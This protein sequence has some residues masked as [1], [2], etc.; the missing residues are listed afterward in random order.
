MSIYIL[1]VLWGQPIKLI[2]VVSTSEF[3]EYWWNGLDFIFL[4]PQLVAGPQKPQKLTTSK[5]KYEHFGSKILISHWKMDIIFQEI[6]FFKHLKCNFKTSWPQKFSIFKNVFTMKITLNL[7]IKKRSLTFS[8]LKKQHFDVGYPVC[9]AYV[10]IRRP[11]PSTDQALPSCFYFR[12]SWI[13]MERPW[14][15]FFG[16]C[17][18]LRGLGS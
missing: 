9:M 1:D 17:S 11:V 13:L 7:R 5:I 16:S 4:S 3:L 12:I 14:K 6:E 2:Q 8:K 10:Y 18:F 15:H